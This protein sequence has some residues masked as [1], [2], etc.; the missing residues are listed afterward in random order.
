[1]TY[2]S[3]VE[4]KGIYKLLDFFEQKILINLLKTPNK[5]QAN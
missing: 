2:L 1:M 3:K 4:K 5:L